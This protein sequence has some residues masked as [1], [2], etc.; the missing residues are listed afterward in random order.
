[1]DAYLPQVR[2]SGGTS[3]GYSLLQVVAVDQSSSL[4]VETLGTS[5][6]TGGLGIGARRPLIL[7]Q[8][9]R[10]CGTSKGY[11]LVQKFVSKGVGGDETN[12]S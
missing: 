4:Q 11:S 10:S 1:M 5:L 12:A 6:A 7:P 3:K 8:V 9:R 2:R